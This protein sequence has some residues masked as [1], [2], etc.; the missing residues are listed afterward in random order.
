MRFFSFFTLRQWLTVPFTVLMFGVAVLIGALSYGTGSHAVD[1][2]S[3]HLLQEM[4]ARI[5]QAVDRHVVGSA[6]VLEAA[7]PNGMAAPDL[8]DDDLAALRTRFWIATSLHLDPNNFVYYGNTHGQAFGLWRYNLQDAELR[9]KLQADQPRM[10]SRF[11]GIYGSLG[12]PTYEAKIFDPRARPWYKAGEISE[13]YTWTSIYIDFTTAELVATRARRVLDTQ[14]RFQGVVATDMSLQRLNEFVKNLAISSHGVAF[15]IEP[16]GKLIA[17]SRSPNTMRLPDGSNARVNAIDSDS[18]L[19]RAAYVQVRDILASGRQMD[20]PATHLFTGPEGA[21]VELAFDHVLDAA[22]LNWIIV[23]AVP[24]SDFMQGI[25]ANVQRTVLI[26]LVG[27]LAAV[28]LGLSILSWVGRDIKRLTQ[29]VQDVGEGHLEAPLDVHRDDEIGVL[30]TT[31]RKMQYRLR[32]DVLTGL[33]N[34]D[35]MM[36]SIASRIEHKRRLQDALPFAVLFVDLN[37]FKTINDCF[38]H[39]A[40]DRVL[41]EIAERLSSVTRP[42]DLVARYAGDEF[43]VLVNDI[44]SRQAAEQV[45]QN[46]EATLREPLAQ[47]DLKTVPNVGAFGAAVGLAMYPGD[48]SCADDLIERADKEMYLR[49]RASREAI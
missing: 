6:A 7:F 36:R 4:V 3:K 18:P 12:P 5:G 24:R 2:V 17:S 44:P 32:T 37:N 40:G 9:Y 29:A 8:I 11:S 28:A 46:L 10:F 16:D 31:F 22:G 47:V 1:T 30:A 49:K 35:M 48:G 23:V 15:I 25:T 41:I 42:G 43:V 39:D 45:R 19:Q 34:R 13:S 27:A 21:A 38:G 33:N 26:G 20:G 14:G